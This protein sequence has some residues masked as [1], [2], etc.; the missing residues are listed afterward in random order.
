MSLNWCHGKRSHTVF[1]NMILS[2][3]GKCAQQHSTGCIIPGFFPHARH[4]ENSN[5][6]RCLKNPQPP[7]FFLPLLLFL[8]GPAASRLLLSPPPLETKGSHQPIDH[9]NLPCDPVP[10]DVPPENQVC[11][12]LLFVC[13]L[14]VFLTAALWYSQQVAHLA[15]AATAA[16][17]VETYIL[18]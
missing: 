12:M 18:P 6:K 2:S 11:S 13:S 17:R 3:E 15:A 16:Q 1:I 10:N 8:L 4:M 14:P 9:A 5:F 7:F